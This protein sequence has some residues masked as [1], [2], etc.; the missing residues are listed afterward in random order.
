MR[1]VMYLFESR[2][3]RPF[4]PSR[5]F[6][7]SRGLAKPRQTTAGD[8]T[9][10]QACPANNGGSGAAAQRSVPDGTPE[11][12]QALAASPFIAAPA[13]RV[14][15]KRATHAETRIPPAGDTAA[16]H[17]VFTPYANTPAA[18]SRFSGPRTRCN[19]ARRAPLLTDLGAGEA[20][21]TL[22]LKTRH[23]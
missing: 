1:A 18:P 12:D 22:A 4:P 7:Q 19:T 5:R 13:K 21:T 14:W 6:G 8:Q 17:V 10:S 11:R 16:A 9:A 23:E 3:R 15:A 2:S 20:N